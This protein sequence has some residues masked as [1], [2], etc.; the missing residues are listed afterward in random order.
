MLNDN[1]S[2]SQEIC[3]LIQSNQLLYLLQELPPENGRIVIDIGS[4]W[5]TCVKPLALLG[6]TV[7]S[8]DKD[9]RHIDYQRGSGFCTPPGEDSFLY[10]YWKL[11]NPKLIS[12]TKYFQKYCENAKEKNIKFI[13]GDFTKL[14]TMQQI[15]H[16]RWD[17]VLALDS[18]HF[19]S[20]AEREKASI[21]IDKRLVK[22]GVVMVKANSP[23]NN[24]IYGFYVKDLLFQHFSKYKV[25][26]NIDN[27]TEGELTLYKVHD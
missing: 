8:I 4:G 27:D 15:S 24:N 5:G 16:R 25:L 26:T 21:L 17:I 10:Q 9:I 13:V 6:Y 3:H 20:P 11:S 23:T 22:G 12:D 14:E 19:M 7:Y 1:G 18:M 2:A